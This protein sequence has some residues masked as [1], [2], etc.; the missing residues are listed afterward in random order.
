MT[1]R[2]GGLLYGDWSREWPK[3]GRGEGIFGYDREDAAY[4]DAVGGSHMVT[5]VRAKSDRQSAIGCIL[6]Q[7]TR[8]SRC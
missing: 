2:S 8:S 3:A 7:S 1:E 5:I 6:W 4:L